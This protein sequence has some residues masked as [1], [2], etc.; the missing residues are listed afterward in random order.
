MILL[1]KE[2]ERDQMAGL[3]A[4]GRGRSLLFHQTSDTT[5]SFFYQVFSSQRKT[6]E[7]LPSGFLVKNVVSLAAAREDD[8]FCTL[9]SVCF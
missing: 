5:V 6:G 2:P 1:R 9:E 3:G 7:V 8:I 4:V